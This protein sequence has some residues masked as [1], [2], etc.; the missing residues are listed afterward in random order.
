[1]PL[2]LL[3]GV[4]WLALGLTLCAFSP[5]FGQ[6]TCGLPTP[7]A[8]LRC[9]VWVT[10]D[11]PRSIED[12]FALAC[13]HGLEIRTLKTTYPTP[14]DGLPTHASYPIQPGQRADSLRRAWTASYL[15]HMIE[16]KDE[17]IERWRKPSAHVDSRARDSF[18]RM[19]DQMEANLAWAK[20]L[21]P[22]TVAAN[23]AAESISGVVYGKGG[24]RAELGEDAVSGLCLPWI[25][26]WPFSAADPSV[27]T[28]R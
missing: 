9:D 7:L 18:A 8:G 13:R 26:V 28:R 14:P 5:A 27:S 3:S 1:M 17:L 21:D 19:A 15:Y 11:P 20:T 10:L 24:L 2:P 4:R 25:N 6:E 12:A 22:E 16:G 23:L